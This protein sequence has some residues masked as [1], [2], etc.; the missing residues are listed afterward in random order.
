VYHEGAVDDPTGATPAGLAG[1]DTGSS[2]SGA[3]SPGR[4]IIMRVTAVGAIPGRARFARSA[5]VRIRADPAA[6]PEAAGDLVQ[7]LTWE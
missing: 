6:E 3:N 2:K 4:N 5:V 7:I 1:A